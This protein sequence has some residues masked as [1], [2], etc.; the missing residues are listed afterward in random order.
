MSLF[1]NHIWIRIFLSL[2]NDSNTLVLC[3]TLVLSAI[4]VGENHIIFIIFHPRMK[5]KSN[6]GVCVTITIMLACVPKS[7]TE[8]FFVFFCNI[9]DGFFTLHNIQVIVFS[10][11]FTL[12][13]GKKIDLQS[14]ISCGRRS[15]LKYYMFMHR[16]YYIEMIV[17]VCILLKI[18]TFFPFFTPK[19]NEFV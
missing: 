17:R 5:S 14:N 19:R 1:W 12:S 2:E 15:K 11:L 3:H 4:E 16:M 18:P 9:V 8:S 10:D 13:C 6:R 7:F